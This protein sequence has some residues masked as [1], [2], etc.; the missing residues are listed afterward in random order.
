MAIVNIHEAT[1]YVSKLVPRAE[2]GEEIVIGRV[3]RSRRGLVPVGR[4]AARGRWEQRTIVTREPQIRA[5]DVAT[6]PG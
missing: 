6:M 1:T 4:R 2:A 5:Y 3:G